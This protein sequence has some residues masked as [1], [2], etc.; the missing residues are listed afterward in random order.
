MRKTEENLRKSEEIYE[1]I[2][3]KFEEKWGN[4]LRSMRKIWGKVSKVMKI[5]E[6]SYEE[7]WGKLWR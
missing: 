5:N 3:G 4:L 6:K 1:D 7:K 2:W